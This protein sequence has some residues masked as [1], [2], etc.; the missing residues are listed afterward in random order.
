MVERSV[1]NEQVE[2]PIVIKAPR[3]LWLDFILVFFTFSLYSS[4]WFVGRTREFNQLLNQK[5]IP[6]LWFF[7]PIAAIAQ[8]FALPKFVRALNDLSIK[9]NV[10]KWKAWS[11]SWVIA[12]FS[13][14]LLIGI[15]DRIEFPGWFLF[16]AIFIW[17][18]LMTVIQS[19]VNRVKLGL[20]NVTFKGSKNNFS[21][22]E[23]LF[24]VPFFMFTVALSYPLVIQPLLT[25]HLQELSKDTAYIDK[26]NRF[27]FPVKGEGW[28]I[29]EAG[30]LSD[31]SSELELQGPLENMSFVVF[32]HGVNQSI[33]SISEWRIAQAV[34]ENSS[35]KCK[36]KRSFA[37]SQLSV[38]SRTNCW[39]RD[40]AGPILI[41][42]SLIEVEKEIFELY[43]Q[44]S[45]VNVSFKNHMDTMREMSK[46]F[47]PL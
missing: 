27:D 7:V 24:L 20:Q 3:A 8:P 38:V 34:D 39:G 43:G 4:F 14:S 15:S 35:I 10:P 31:G 40:I 22:I 36:E 17:S 41:T 30:S 21:I 6:W 42:I 33:S 44:L 25:V 12:C 1:E 47:E 16:L 18:C 23:W 37:V 11:S 46:G 28:S 5:F 13:I 32:N 45:A 9:S 19:K 29:V 2:A 26:Q